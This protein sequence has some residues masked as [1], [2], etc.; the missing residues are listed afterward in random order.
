MFCSKCGANVP[1]GSTSCSNCGSPA[2]ASASA[3]PRAT[4]AQPMAPSPARLPVIPP[5]ELPVEGKA[6]ASLVFGILSVTCFGFLAG[7]PAVILGHMAQSSIRQSGGRLGGQGRATAG[8]IMG[9]IS[10][11]VIP[12][13]LIIA[14]IAIPNLLRSRILA[15]ESAAASTMRVINTAQVTYESA[16]SGYARDITKLGPGPSGACSDNVTADHASLLDNVVGC[17]SAWCNK[18]GY[19]FNVTGTD[20]GDN[21]VCKD[22]VVLAVPLR[23]NATGTRRFC[24]TSDLVIRSQLGDSTTGPPTVEQ[25]QS[26][27]PLPN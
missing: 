16:N 19:T 17:N 10:V 4:P 2:M 7:I 6:T 3:P 18:D 5:G 25:C 26:W 20:C 13:I 11:A 9:Y 21:G 8:L 23:P 24:T 1:E 22:Y 14:A 15:N 12:I 27:L